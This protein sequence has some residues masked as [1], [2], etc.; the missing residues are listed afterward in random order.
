METKKFFL[1]SAAATGVLAAGGLAWYGLLRTFYK[2]QSGKGSRRRKPS[3]AA[4]AVARVIY[5]V[6]IAAMY[7][8]SRSNADTPVGRGFRTGVLTGA[9]ASIPSSLSEYASFRI[10]L[11]AALLTA[12]FETALAGAAGAVVG[13][14]YGDFPEPVHQE[15]IGDEMFD[16]EPAEGPVE[17]ESAVP[18]EHNGHRIGVRHRM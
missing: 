6:G 8:R 3:L 15:D 17:E 13:R 4:D 16:R 7:P 2:S 1:A 10:S 5:G 11:P 18:H 12:G 9:V 14:I